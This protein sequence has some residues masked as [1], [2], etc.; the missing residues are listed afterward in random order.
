MRTRFV[1]VLF[2]LALVALPMAAAN[3][4]LGNA[5]ISA[6]GIDWQGLSAHEQLTLVV[7]GPDGVNFTKT[8][9]SAAA[10]GLHLGDFAAQ[11]GLYHYDL[12]FSPRVPPGIANQLSAA[13]AKNDDAAVK[14][15][16]RANGLDQVI[17][18]SGVF[19]ISNGRFIVPSESESSHLVAANSSSARTSSPS[20]TN[21]S[22]GAGGSGSTYNVLA[23]G[24]LQPK[25]TDVV[26][27]DDEIIQGSLCVGLD[28]VVNES[29]GFDTIRLKENNDRIKFDDTSTSAGYPNN[30]W[31]LT[32]NDS[33]SGGANKFSIEDIT[34]AKVPFTVTAGAPTNSMFVASTG[35]LGLGNSSPGL[36]IHITTTDTPAIRQEQTN[37]GGFTA[38]TWDIG[39]NEANWFVRDV[40]GGSR[41]PLRIRPGA[42]TSSV[43]IAASGFVGV[44][45][46]SPATNLNVFGA[47]AH[48]MAGNATADFLNTLSQTGY[49]ASNGTEELFFG[50]QSS[51]AFLGSHSNT[52]LGF[53]TNNATKMTI[54]AAG[55]VGIG[56][57]APTSQLVITSGATS[58]SVNAGATAFTVTSS[59][60]FKENIQP[61]KSNDILKKI[62]AVP[63]VTYDFKGDG[64]K[65]RLGLIAEDFY[66]VLGRGDDKHINGQDVEMALWL[67]VQQLTAQNK[68]L[69]DRIN[70]LEKQ[71]T[72]QPT[73]Q[74]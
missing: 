72:S 3:N 41:L 74:Q 65:D 67:A 61:V 44:G 31:Q 2:A 20:E 40:T 22:A 51:L 54:T 52:N 73:T 16:Q 49:S 68:Q 1:S 27:A 8:F 26:T 56:N 39:A 57:T 15:I 4:P 7:Q 29:F 14:A 24:K 42:P 71:L 12:Q 18:L 50:V 9:N 10:A 33:G 59:R 46:A 11:D 66:T 47:N 53:V 35:K 32:A 36:H 62:E 48:V 45:T 64:P 5:V 43:D 21:E 58:S 63:V 30:D 13:R 28:C 19:T 23:Q 25:V 69:T 6:S 70:S 38:Q 60:E 37:G 17:A 55:N 34:G